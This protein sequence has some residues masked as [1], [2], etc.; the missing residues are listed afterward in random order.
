[1]KIIQ[2]KQNC[3]KKCDTQRDKIVNMLSIF[4]C[5]TACRRADNKTA[6]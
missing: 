5:R 1:M 2:E 3:V 6:A 4:Y